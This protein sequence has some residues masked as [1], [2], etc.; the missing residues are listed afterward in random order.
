MMIRLIVFCFCCHKVLNGRPS[1]YASDVYSFGV[2]V[3]EVITTGLPWASS[4]CARDIMCAVING[5]RPVFPADAPAD[6][7]DIARECWAEE[8]DDRPSFKR[9]MEGLRSNV[10]TF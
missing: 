10:S 1:T 3:W 9:I 4:T 7:A 6:I 2:V 8:P 5:A